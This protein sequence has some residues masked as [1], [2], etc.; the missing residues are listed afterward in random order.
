MKFNRS[1]TRTTIGIIMFLLLS[2]MNSTAH[3]DDVNCAKTW[4]LN[5]WWDE[6][7]I[8]KYSPIL[9]NTPTAQFKSPI[10][11]G[12][13]APQISNEALEMIRKQGKNIV[14]QFF[15][16]RKNDLNFDSTF[17]PIYAGTTP[18]SSKTYLQKD[19]E[20]TNLPF[21]QFPNVLTLFPSA[22]LATR[23]RIEQP[24]CEIFEVTSPYHMN[25]NY[26]VPKLGSDNWENYWKAISRDFK[27]IET[28]KE[29]E[30]T[31]L[32]LTPKPLSV[33]N[34]IGINRW[35]ELFR[36]GPLGPT[37]FNYDW[38]NCKAVKT[39]T[40]YEKDI[41]KSPWEMVF[42]EA[43]IYGVGLLTTSK[44]SV[45]TSCL[46]D[47]YFMLSDWYGEPALVL[48]YLG[49]KTIT[50]P[51]SMSKPSPTPSA[52]KSESPA[53]PKPSPTAKRSSTIYCTKGKST[54]KVIGVN[55]KCPSGYKKK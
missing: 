50:I 53:S 26:S 55:P 35:Y 40:E 49:Q 22:E 14:I 3:G 24:N 43:P 7:A 12:L 29:W 30:R 31:F 32:A 33:E 52:T 11:N 54:L 42:L 44:A 4:T 9:G 37:V 1:F 13:F 46:V 39:L 19:K 18:S 16:S 20:Y 28:I 21:L 2:T 38:R 36:S 10:S 51:A 23:L 15:I 17:R 48:F 45:S 8:F 47:I 25:P 41:T 5:S 34:S 27:Q 6:P